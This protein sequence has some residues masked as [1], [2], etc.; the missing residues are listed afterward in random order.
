MDSIL[1]DIGFNKL[2]TNI[3]HDI[4]DGQFKPNAT[5]KEV[6]GAGKDTTMTKRK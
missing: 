3:L 5:S 1:M 4:H 6:Q 2:V